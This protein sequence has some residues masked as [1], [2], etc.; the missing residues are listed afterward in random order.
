MSFVS[1]S[2]FSS[3][4]SVL[5]AVQ[6]R[7]SDTAVGSLVQYVSVSPP[8]LLHADTIATDTRSLAVTVQLQRSPLHV[9]VDVTSASNIFTFL[10][11][12]LAYFSGVYTVVATLM[13]GLERLFALGCA[14]RT[15][16]TSSSSSSSGGMVLCCS[17]AVEVT[18]EDG[19]AQASTP[20]VSGVEPSYDALS[21][22]FASAKLQ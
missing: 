10:G 6:T 20:L 9:Q 13:W 5:Q 21:G 17:G 16:H 8:S 3:E 19:K 18:E 12:L 1:D 11:Q 2:C 7:G 4:L 15:K 14:R 22:S